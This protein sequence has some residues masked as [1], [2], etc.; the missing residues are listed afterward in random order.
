MLT[1]GGFNAAWNPSVPDR[2]PVQGG[3]FPPYRFLD[4]WF[5]SLWEVPVRSPLLLSCVLGRH[6]RSKAI[7]RRWLRPLRGVRGTNRAPLLLRWNTSEFIMTHTPT[8]ATF[9]ILVTMMLPIGFALAQGGGAGG[10]GAGAGGAAG[11]GAAGAGAAGGGRGGVGTSAPGGGA[12]VGG[13]APAGA[14][15]GGSPAGAVGGGAP[16]NNAATNSSAPPAASGSVPAT[17]APTS[18]NPPTTGGVLGGYNGVG[19]PSPAGAGASSPPITGQSSPT[20]PEAVQGVAE[21]PASSSTGLAKTSADG[22]STDI[23]PAKPCST[24]AHETDGTT[25]CVGIPAN[26]KS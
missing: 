10:G 21:Q 5:R 25:T 17:N 16:T 18:A 11:A 8:K 26:A 9:F 7:C 3:G 12:A 4:V 6:W 1:K 15:G 22:T 2:R 23:V 20:V 14:V 13:G 24:T 19:N